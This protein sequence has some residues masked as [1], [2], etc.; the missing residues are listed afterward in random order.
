MT[1][2]KILH[3]TDEE[4][5]KPCDRIKEINEEVFQLA[6][7]LKDT[8]YSTD[9][10]GLA[11]PQIGVLKRMIL[12]DLRNGMDPIIL[13]NPKI[14]SQS[15]KETSIEGCLSYPGYAGEVMRPKAIKVF[16]I[17]LKGEKVNIKADGF[18]ARCFC[19]EID[20]LDGVVYTDR[21]RYIYEEES[22]EE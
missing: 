4:L 18:L 7:D 1:V 19:H 6:E 2:R 13:I 14:T 21:T 15:G 16:G 8:L 10:V 20:H 3:F 11:A 9:G 17:N 5:H 22:S 12:V